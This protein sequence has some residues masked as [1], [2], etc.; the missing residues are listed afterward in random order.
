MRE[1]AAS[2]LAQADEDLATADYNLQGGRFYAAVF[3]AQQAAEKALKGLFIEAMNDLPPKTHNIVRLARQLGGTEDVLEAA[4]ELNPEY[5]TTR[6][7]DA[8]VG[9]PAEMF[10][11]KSAAVH[12]EAARVI[13]QWVRSRLT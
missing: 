3:F 9:I 4:I 6:Y 7:P 1:E 2:W 11:Q 8:A 5:F 13:M 12:L 10:S